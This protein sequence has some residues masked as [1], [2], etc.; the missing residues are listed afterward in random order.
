MQAA[1]DGCQ[2]LLCFKDRFM[3]VFFYARNQVNVTFCRTILKG[4][5][6]KGLQKSPFFLVVYEGKF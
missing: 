5:F 3:P 1:A 4:I 6:R 2:S